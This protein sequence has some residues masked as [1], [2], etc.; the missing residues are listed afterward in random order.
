MKILIKPHPREEIYPW[1]QWIRDAKS[2]KDRGNIE[3]G[4]ADEQST[5]E[6]LAYV[7]A[8]VGLPTSVLI[9]AALAGIPT[10]AIQPEWWPIKNTAIARFLSENVL[11]DASEIPRDFFD[12]S[13]DEG[14]RSLEVK[15]KSFENSCYR[16]IKMIRASANHTL[17]SRQH[18]WGA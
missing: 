14:Y 3:I 11:R 10:I 9:E 18:V 1:R 8:V 16:A 15:V 5:F 2:R 12:K 6:I 4:L 17:T 7:D 13:S